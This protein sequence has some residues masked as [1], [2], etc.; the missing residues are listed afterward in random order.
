[1]DDI[2]ICVPGQGLSSELS[3][4]AGKWLWDISTWVFLGL[5]KIHVSQ[6]EILIPF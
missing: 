4:S 2:Q 3:T 6:T 5:L 1:M